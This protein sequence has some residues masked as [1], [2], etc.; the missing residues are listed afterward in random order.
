MPLVPLV[1]RDRNGW[2][3]NLP[4]VDTVSSANQTVETA[5]KTASAKLGQSMDWFCWE[6]LAGNHGF[7]HF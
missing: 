1:P 4:T 7:S 2:I 3:L 5:P 6:I